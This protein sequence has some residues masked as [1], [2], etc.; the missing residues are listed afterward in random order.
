MTT[1]RR[2]SGALGYLTPLLAVLVV[3]VYGPL[4]CTVVLSV[5]NW[6]GTGPPAF[7]GLHDYAEL[8]SAPEF[9]AALWRTAL[10]VLCVLPF[11]TV[12]PMGLAVLLWK[13]PGRASSVYRALLFLPVL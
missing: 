2:R 1:A 11:A 4:A 9:P 5:L 7:A 3:W 10:L 12:V 8:F 6:D 13:R